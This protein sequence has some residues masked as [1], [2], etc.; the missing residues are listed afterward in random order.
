MYITRFTNKVHFCN[1]FVL[2]CNLKKILSQKHVGDLMFPEVKCIYAV[3]FKK[4]LVN[5]NCCLFEVHNCNDIFC[6]KL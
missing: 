5:Q 4:V 3:F 1:D 2:Y 6:L